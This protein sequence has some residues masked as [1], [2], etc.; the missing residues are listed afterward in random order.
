[1]RKSSVLF[2]GL[3]VH[4][5]SID[6]R[7]LVSRGQKLHIVDEVGPSGFVIER[8]LIAQGLH[9]EVVAPSLIARPS[10][11]PGQDRAARRHAAG[12]AGPLRGSL[13]GG[14]IKF[15]KRGNGSL[16]ILTG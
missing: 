6:L 13:G 16:P 2:V 7:K 15:G 8:H 9:W 1:M 5:G 12:Q 10:R 11:R 3:D 4:E 14:A